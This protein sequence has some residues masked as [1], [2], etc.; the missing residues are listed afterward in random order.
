MSAQPTIGFIGVGEIAEAII[1]GLAAGEDPPRVVAS[2]R[3]RERSASLADRFP[4]L[5]TVAASNQAVVDAADTVVL[6]VLPEQLAEVVGPLDFR[7]DQ[8]VVSALAGVTTAEVAAAAGAPVPVIRAIPMPP[9]RDRAVPTVVTPDH[10]AARAL[11]D[12]TG[13][14]LAVADEEE[15]AVF[16]AAT[17]AVSG[18]LEYLAV[19]CAWTEEQG[20]P[21]ESGQR[22]LRGLFGALAPAIRDESTPIA[23]VVTAHETPGGLNEQLRLEVFDDAGTD[24]LSGALD[25]LH[26]RVRGAS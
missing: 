13:G 4:S 15:L 19:V 9:V 20:V 3:G 22:F 11:F 7:D 18:F 5:V 2:P 1:E 17:G 26:A 10:P 25:R 16:S 12:R 21:R 14:T 8:V 23:D 24:A 6:A